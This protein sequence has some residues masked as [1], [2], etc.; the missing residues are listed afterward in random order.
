LGTKL[1]LGAVDANGTNPANSATLVNLCAG[2]SQITD[3]ILQV[4]A[5]YS[6]TPLRLLQWWTPVP[7]QFQRPITVSVHVRSTMIRDVV[8]ASVRS[9]KLS[10]RF[11]Q[12]RSLWCVARN[13]R[14][15]VGSCL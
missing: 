13:D 5:P 8:A 4:S 3:C 14:V 7:M 10:G 11:R 1:K 2:R 6:T 12:K 15:W 9:I